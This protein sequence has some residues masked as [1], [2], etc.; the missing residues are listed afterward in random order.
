M[1]RDLSQTSPGPFG[2]VA[3][4]SPVAGPIPQ[5]LIICLRIVRQRCRIERNHSGCL[6]RLPTF[7]RADRCV[8]LCPRPWAQR[9][10]VFP[11]AA[12]SH[13]RASLQR[14]SAS[15]SRSWQTCPTN[16]L[17]TWVDCR[18]G[19]SVSWIVIIAAVLLLV[20]LAAVGVAW[21]ALWYLGQGMD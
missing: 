19:L 8:Q 13:P 16:L 11:Q 1:V 9:S 5:Q 17:K 2:G 18:A 21:A 14:R 7:S 4:S 10:S 3:L 6:D 20:F 15:E 12:A